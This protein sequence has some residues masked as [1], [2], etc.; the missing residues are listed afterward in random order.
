M[1]DENVGRRGQA[2]DR[3]KI[4]GKIEREVGLD[5]R[6]NGVGDRSKQ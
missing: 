3:H 6:I 2:Y 5:G 4:F 1:H